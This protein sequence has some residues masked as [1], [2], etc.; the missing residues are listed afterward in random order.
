MVSSHAIQSPFR[1]FNLSSSV[2]VTRLPADVERH[3][4]VFDHVPVAKVSWSF[5]NGRQKACLLDL[6]P[7]SESKE[8]EEVDDENG[9]V[10]G[11]IKH[12]G[13]GAEQGDQSSFG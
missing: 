11:D 5:E 8:H 4:F 10:H 2:A 12:L 9:P 3:V 1:L 13:E 7:H 6:L